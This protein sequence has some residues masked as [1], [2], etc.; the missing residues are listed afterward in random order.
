MFY[1]VTQK[2]G[3]RSVWEIDVVARTPQEAAKK[4]GAREMPWKNTFV[5][6]ESI[7]SKE[8]RTLTP[9]RVGGAG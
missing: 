5:Q 6:V 9:R 7:R 4:S 1:R 3:S 8:V 2:V